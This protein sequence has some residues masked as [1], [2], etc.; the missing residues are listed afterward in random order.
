MTA[1]SEYPP[2]HFDFTRDGTEFKSW[3]KLHPCHKGPHFN[4]EWFDRD[5]NEIPAPTREEQAANCPHESVA[6][7]IPS[8][9]KFQNEIQSI[10][11]KFQNRTGCSLSIGIGDSL[12]EALLNLRIAKL[13]GKDTIVGL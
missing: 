10:K 2:H 4:G 12:Q 8:E 7:E 6:V 3:C 5:G 11:S 9:D 1:S 13:K